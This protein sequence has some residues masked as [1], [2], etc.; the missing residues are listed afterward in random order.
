MIR[1]IGVPVGLAL[2]AVAV[3]GTVVSLVAQRRRTS[4]FEPEVLPEG[5]RTE[6]PLDISPDDEARYIL[7]ALSLRIRTAGASMG[8]HQYFGPGVEVPPP[9]CSL[10]NSLAPVPARFSQ[11]VG[12]RYASTRDEWIHAG[13]VGNMLQFFISFPQQNQY[14]WD[15]DSGREGHLTAVLDRD[16]DGQ[17]D[18]TFVVPIRCD[19]ECYCAP[20]MLT[21]HPLTGDGRP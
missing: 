17:P 6:L 3:C 9:L 4:D 12:G 19:K 15:N 16:G 14:R 2:A 13:W 20:G 11:I 1:R 8:S 5:A 21:K 10:P 18:T 7:R